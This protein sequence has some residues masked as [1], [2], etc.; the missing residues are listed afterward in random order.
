MDD[1]AR[2]TELAGLC[3]NCLHARL[4]RSDRGAVF[5]QCLRAENDSQYPRYP[6]LPVLDCK[7]YEARSESDDLK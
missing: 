2:E 6:R 4:L 7:G 5:Y 3:A 1:H